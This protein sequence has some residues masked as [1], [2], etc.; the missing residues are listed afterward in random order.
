MLNFLVEFALF[1]PSLYAINEYVAYRKICAQATI[2]IPYF[3]VSSVYK[4]RTMNIKT[5]KNTLKPN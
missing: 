3:Q 1:K 4:I 5:I 2:S